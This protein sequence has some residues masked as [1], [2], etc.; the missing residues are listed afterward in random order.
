[1]K[2]KFLACLVALF[3]VA[4][5]AAQP[6]AASVSYEDDDFINQLRKA[7]GIVDESKGYDYT[8]WG[9]N[10]SAEE[11]VEEWYF[12]EEAYD[13]QLDCTEFTTNGAST[14]SL[15]FDLAHLQAFPNDTNYHDDSEIDIRIVDPLGEY[16]ELFDG[17]VNQRSAK[18]YDNTP[19]EMI[20]YPEYFSIGKNTMSVKAHFTARGAYQLLLIIKNVYG[21]RT[22]SFKFDVKKG[23]ADAEN[24]LTTDKA[25]YGKGSSVPVTIKYSLA[26]DGYNYYM[27]FV[28]PDNY[29]F[30]L[31]FDHSYEEDMPYI[32]TGHDWYSSVGE[33]ETTVGKVHEI[34]DKLKLTQNGTYSVVIYNMDT[35]KKVM[36]HDFLVSDDAAAI[37]VDT[38]TIKNGL[39]PFSCTAD[40][41][42]LSL[43]S[44]DKVTMTFQMPF[45]YNSFMTDVVYD[46]DD[47]DE[48]IEDKAKIKVSVYYTPSG[49]DTARMIMSLK[50]F[51]GCLEKH[52]VTLKAS[53]ILDAILETNIND[54]VFAG[55]V[56][57]H[58]DYDEVTSLY[59]KICH[60]TYNFSVAKESKLVKAKT[61]T[62]KVPRDYGENAKFYAESTAGGDI[63]A[64]IYKG[65]KKVATVKAPSSL[66]QTSEDNAFGY[67]NWDLKNSSGKY[68]STGSYKAKIYTKTVLTVINGEDTTKNTIKS[69]VKTVK[70]KIVKSTGTLKLSASA[71]SSAGGDYVTYENPIMGIIT[72]VTVGSKL[73]IKIKNPSGSVV[74]TSTFEQGKGSGAAWYNLA[75]IDS[76]YKLGT[77][78][79]DITAETLGGAKKSATVKFTV[80]KSPKVNISGTSLSVSDGIGTISFNTSQPSQVTIKVKD[81][82]G[83]VKIN[84]TDKY[85]SAG[86]IKT[87]FAYG[88]LA[89]GT[90]NVSVSATNSG[91]TSTDT[92]SFTVKAKPVVVKKPTLSNLRIKWTTKNK[93][94]A[95][96]ITADYTEKGAKVYFEVLWNDAE[97]IVYTYTTTTSAASGSVS[98]TWDGYKANG[99][100][101]TPGSY[102]IRAYAVNSA[103]ATSYI[104]Q[105]FTISVG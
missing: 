87:S 99:F 79:A 74:K 20:Y 56:S 36:V 97:E 94:D 81:S 58:F 104:R 9:D 25:I 5:F 91:G 80:K 63:Y 33:M 3:M 1:M 24:M 90:Y 70:F 10:R 71:V 73:T 88:S 34:T 14:V 52:T 75:N 67:L 4:V 43:D 49:S 39:V 92:K 89:V 27:Y 93:E 69:N 98:Y 57:V 64:E 78:S 48:G 8:I 11:F 35:K 45:D 22:Y 105:N 7:L 2:K 41:T 96:T 30:N 54:S 65:K 12:D 13:P 60:E 29:G 19:T 40:A 26:D 66:G 50:D 103:G 72:D 95:L 59:A 42:H 47:F 86:T 61:T 102:T 15:S 6:V 62:S 100:R 21:D 82:Q 77:Y 28:R 32:I 16:I 46:D 37:D 101:A 85:Y 51:T 23:N 44:N 76:N 68:C 84:V 55:I 31:C 38:S 83:N 53:D 17:K 18:R